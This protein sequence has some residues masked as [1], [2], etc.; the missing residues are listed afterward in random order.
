MNAP[1][2]AH[3]LSLSYDGNG[4][5]LPYKRIV[6]P[7]L[8]ERLYGGIGEKSIGYPRKVYRLFSD[9]T[10]QTIRYLP[11]FAP[12]PSYKR[13]VPSHPPFRYLRTKAPLPPIPRSFS[14]VQTI[15]I[16]QSPAPTSPIPSFGTFV[17][18]LQ[19]HPHLALSSP[20]FPSDTFV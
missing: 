10:V 11:S 13:F 15:R 4:S 16:Q 3:L 6:A 9:S 8:F 14:F 1:T 5:L 20:T 19:Y 17:Q 2:Y 12:F 18:A 7:M